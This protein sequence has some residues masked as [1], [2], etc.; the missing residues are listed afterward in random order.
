MTDDDGTSKVFPAS[1]PVDTALKL[2]AAMGSVIYGCL[3]LAY[4]NFYSAVHVDPGEVGNNSLYIL[5]RCLGF[6]AVSTTVILLYYAL[7]FWVSSQTGPKTVVFEVLALGLGT[8]GLIAL[9]LLFREGGSALVALSMLCVGFFGTHLVALA[10]QRRSQAA[11]RALLAACAVS[12]AL[13]LP[14]VATVAQAGHMAD[15]VVRG[16]AVTP[17]VVLGV[18]VLDIVAP[19]ATITWVGPPTQRPENVFAGRTF[20]GLLIAQGPTSITVRATIDKKVEFV[21]LP[22]QQVA[23]VIR[24]ER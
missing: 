1:L 4:R 14:G 8:A 10:V 2:V 20:D 5:S 24:D 16:H 15:G 21:R 3:F 17:Y 12:V 11:S 22:V 18:P 19:R 6:L 13:V 9:S 23:V 7:W